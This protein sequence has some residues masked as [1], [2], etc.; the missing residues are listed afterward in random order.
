MGGFDDCVL[1][2]S[3]FWRFA[4]VL[5]FALSGLGT[6]AG[7]AAEAGVGAG[8]RGGSAAQQAFKEGE[9]IVRFPKMPDQAAPEEVK[10]RVHCTEEPAALDP[11]GDTF[12]VHVPKGYRGTEPWGLVVWV[13]PS[14]SGRPPQEWLRVLE[15]RRLLWVGAQKAGNPRNIFARMQLALCANA[16]MRERFR[17]D[18]RRVYVSGFS[19]GG[20]V[21]SILGVAWADMFSGSV[22]MMGVN[23]FTDLP[24]ADGKRVYA[25]QYIPDDMVLGIAR[26]RTRHVLVT[27]EKDF[28]RADT[29][30]VFEKGYQQEGFR[31]V[32]L[33]EV[34]GIGH[35]LPGG[36]WF[37]KA[38]E[39]LEKAR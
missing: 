11:E 19:G 28:N 17:V 34:P 29:R 23:F 26:E 12:V 22:P 2:G 15:E 20:R 4:G 39:L 8:G 25:P 27:S 36:E 1:K 13:S 31:R 21:A 32:D 35:A 7:S 14:D 33:L 9:S 30:I 18:G 6:G 3:V 16:G 38:L 24:A 37:A 5:L 10:A